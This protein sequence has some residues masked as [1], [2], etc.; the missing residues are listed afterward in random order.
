MTI[1]PT[2]TTVVENKVESIIVNDKNMD[3]SKFI[4]NNNKVEKPLAIE[5][6]DKVKRRTKQ[7]HISIDSHSATA[8][9]F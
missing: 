8:S 9:I 5:T 7:G 3:E 2:V 6:K 1:D 4:I